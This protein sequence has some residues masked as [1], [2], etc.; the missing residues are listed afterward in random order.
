MARMYPEQIEGFEEATEGERKVFAF[1]KEAARPHKDFT[2]WYQ[3][4]VGSQDKVPDFILYGK[5]LGLLVLEVKDWASHQILA[6]TP[7]HF[8]VQFSGKSEQKT[9]PLRQ[10]KTYTHALMERLKEMPDFFSKEPAHEGGLKIPVGRMVVF[11]NISRKEYEDR[12]IRWIIP[13]E[14]ALLREDLD[15]AGEILADGSGRKFQQ[16]ISGAFPFGFKGLTGKEE[17]KLHF[18]LWPE[19]RIRL[20]ERQGEGR[21]LFRKEVTALDEAQAR[22]ALL[23]GPGHQIIKGP[24]GCGK[25]LVL[26]HRCCQLRRYQPKIRKILLVCFNIALVSYLKRLIQ[27]R[28][29][30]T[31]EGGIQ[32]CHFFDLCSRVL[33]ETVRFEN[34]SAEYY[35][36]VTQETLDRIAAGKSHVEPFDAVLVD[37]GQDFDD[38]ML[39]VV[40]AL[41]KP[42]G[43][44]VLSLDSYQDLYMRRPS[45]KSAG[46][47]AGGR[48]HY[49]KRV[50]RN[51]KAIFDFTQRFIGERPREKGQLA[52]L[53]EGIS[54]EGEAPEILKFENAGEVERFLIEDLKACVQGGQY[55]RSETAI[56]Y[57]DKVYGPDRFS[58]DNRALPMRLLRSL[59]GA[60]IPSTWVSQDV[61]SKEMYDVT[62]DRVSLISIHS[63]KGLDFDLVYL[64]GLDHIHRTEETRQ[65]L[66]PLV[67]V[68]MTRAKC[69][70]V[71]PYV[72]ET[73]LI[74][75]I[76]DCLPK[77]DLRAQPI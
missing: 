43:D 36:L 46:I 34:E 35:E 30:G 20:P 64:V 71:I 19:G 2:I 40:L 45:W 4:S 63:S 1:L 26:V 58:Y 65:N 16:R 60:G 51:T 13:M 57:D 41:L 77:R 42:G 49:L 67:Y 11:P 75:R 17:A 74:R 5:K 53:P 76:K 56:L 69:R 3:P 25:T 66:V 73:E 10:A 14:M 9:N 7:H 29:I 23:L 22:L 62:T 21:E 47:K 38:L 48:A 33:G 44:F 55:K 32:V 61:R 6:Y 59:E 18:A 70:L 28:A 54:F 52:L 68:A 39:R 50:Y 37:E 72:E 8:T 31:G 24:P 12:G 27:E 15:P